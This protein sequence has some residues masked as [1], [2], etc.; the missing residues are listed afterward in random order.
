MT[1]A[2]VA[3]MCFAVGIAVGWLGNAFWSNVGPN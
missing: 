2:G 1:C 3:L